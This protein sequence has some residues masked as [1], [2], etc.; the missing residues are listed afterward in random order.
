MAAEFDQELVNK[1]RPAI[2]YLS[3]TL[4]IC[5]VLLDLATYKWR[6]CADWIILFELVETMISDYA[7]PSREANYTDYFLAYR[8][9]TGFIMWYTDTRSQIICISCA[10]AVIAFV[11]MSLIFNEQLTLSTAFIK[12]VSV[13]VVFLI[14]SL[15][16]MMILYISSMHKKVELC[17]VEN[18]KLLD[19]MHEGLLILS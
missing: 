10:Q 15:L 18:I 14:N 3:M 2:R 8:L 5:A 9:L 11:N 19:G 1:I 7:I 4:I 16:A 13:L 12:V 17:N 6:I